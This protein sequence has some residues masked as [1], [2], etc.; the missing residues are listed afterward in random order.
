VNLDPV[1]ILLT[2]VAALLLVSVGSVV[3]LAAVIAW[4]DRRSLRLGYFGLPPAGRERYR[5]TLRFHARMLAPVI[6]VTAR[7]SPFS[8]D[9]ASF[10]YHGVSGPRG[11]CTPESFRAGAAY[12]PA[13]EDVFVV[14]QMRSGTTWMQQL[15]YEILMRGAGDLVD[16]GRTLNA[17]SPWIEAV[18][19]VPVEDAPRLGTHRPSRVIKTH[20]PLSLCPYSSQAKYI[21]V[22]RHP[23]SCFASCVDFLAGSLGPSMPAIDMVEDWFC[24]DRM[25][26]SSWPRHV[27]D[28]YGRSLASDNILFVHYETMIARL[29]VVAADVAAFLGVPPLNEHE[30]TA[31]TLKA[32]FDYMKRNTS[33]FEMYPP[34]LLAVDGTYFRKGTADRDRDVSP[35]VRSRV[36]RW[37]SAE[38]AGSSFPL[39]HFYPGSSARAVADVPAPPAGHGAN[40]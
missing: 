29:P 1:T 20:F 37:C 27:A 17:V 12:A 18:I 39:D 22:V 23:V 21:Y 36:L 2:V 24:S 7:A 40:E 15:V 5:R 26:W 14:T 33:T 4:G 6:R 30:M 32:G 11:A 13:A 9:K 34:N 16:E 31:V 25:W 28:W 19:G 38:L 10:D 8:F 35:D 3:W